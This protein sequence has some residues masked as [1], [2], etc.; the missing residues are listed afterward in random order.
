MSMT[1]VEDV[2]NDTAPE[3]RA[4]DRCDQ[5]GAQAYVRVTPPAGSVVT[6]LLFCAHDYAKNEAKL[7]AAG[8]GVQD[9]RYRLTVRD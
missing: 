5:C 1:A 2:Q 4:T 8:W 3:L 9:E 7:L 6:G